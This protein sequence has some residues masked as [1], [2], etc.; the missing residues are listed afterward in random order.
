MKLYCRESGQ[1]Q[2]LIILHG[3]F[4][5][6]DNWLTI[7]K[8]FAEHFHVFLVD[9]RNHGQSPHADE[10][11]YTVMAAD[12]QEFIDEH[13]LKDPILIG[14]SMGGKTVMKFITTYNTPVSKA[15]IV[16]IAPKYYSQHHQ[17]YI[18]AMTSLDLASLQ[19]RQDLE[20]AFIGG[21]VDHLGERQFLMKNLGR[22]DSG[23]FYWKINLKGLVNQIENIGEGTSTEAHCEIPVLFIK[24]EKSEYYINKEDAPLIHQ[25]FPNSRI[26]TIKD[27]GHW[28]QAEQP[29]AFFNEVIRFINGK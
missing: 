18:K 10:H 9:Q 22:D 8:K 2:P 13:Q 14:H 20:N 21:G 26:V 29:E 28:V 3:L 5:S 12:L 1:G 6:S 4:G 24:G 19:S 15:I 25:I 7:S 17:T 11:N 23:A 16:D 27:S